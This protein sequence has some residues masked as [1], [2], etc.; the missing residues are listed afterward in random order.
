MADTNPTERR[1]R[2]TNVDQHPGRPD[3]TIRKRRTKAEIARDN[4][5]QEEKRDRKQLQRNQGIAR[6]ASLE[7]QM[8]I[9]DA[10][11]EDAHPRN[12]KGSSSLIF[13]SL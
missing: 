8:A 9:D 7:D 4:A 12:Q 10:S 11:A 3:V 1:T 6:I 2:A 13:F 5:L